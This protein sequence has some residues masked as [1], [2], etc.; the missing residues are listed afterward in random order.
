MRGLYFT[1]DLM[2][3]SRVM[4]VAQAVGM[5]LETAMSP[6]AFVEQLSHGDVT[7]A[8][9][10][11]TAPECDP[12]VLVPQVLA[13][14]PQAQIVAYGPHV[15]HER[16]AAALAAGCHRVFSRGQF[17]QELAAILAESLR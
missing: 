2:Y 11:L 1:T 8:I 10:D 7:L 5:P 6:A 9:L 4:S 15:D 16:L 3:S 13:A 14:A 12:A 17:V